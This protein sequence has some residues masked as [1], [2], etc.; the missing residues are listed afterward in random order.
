MKALLAG[1]FL[2][3]GTVSLIRGLAQARAFG[4]LAIVLGGIATIYVGAALA[5]GRT[6][7]MLVEGL[8]ACAFIVLATLG[9]WRSPLWLVIGYLG[10]GF[11][12]LAHQQKRLPTRITTW[13]PP[14]CLIYDWVIAGAICLR[15]FRG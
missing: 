14:F 9:I 1:A 6:C 12:D 11:W 13:W 15:W 10:H 3:G 7:Q 2:A 8:A 4:L 5:T